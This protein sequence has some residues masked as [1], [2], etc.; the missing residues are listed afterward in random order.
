MPALFSRAIQLLAD[1]LSPN[2]FASFLLSLARQVEPS[3]M[4]HLFPLP[5]NSNSFETIQDLYIEVVRGGYLA[6]PSASLPL[7]STKLSALED[8]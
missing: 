6:T 2:D 8:M 1:A 4:E 3:C 5:H 7:L